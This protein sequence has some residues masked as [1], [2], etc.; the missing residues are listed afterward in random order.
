MQAAQNISQV[1]MGVNLKC[2][3]C[4]DSFIN[5]WKLADAYGLASV[6]ADGPLEMVHCDK[7]TGQDR[8]DAGSSIRSSARSTRQAVAR[9]R[10]KQL[11]DIDDQPKNGRLTRTIVNRLWAAASWAAGSSSRWTTW[12]SRLESRICSTGWRRISSTNGYDLKQHDRADPDLA[13]VSVAGRCRRG[14]TPASVYVFRG[15]S[16][17]RMTAEQFV[18]AVERGHRRLAV[19]RRRRAAMFAARRRAK[20]CFAS[21]V[22]SWIW[23]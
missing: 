8:A 19:R 1:F 16:V 20:R 9:E 10:L 2:A 18:D 13:R 15:P 4:H 5:D 17:R 11:A 21:Q 23:S 22:A 7:P 12:S 6:Y 14:E 3:S